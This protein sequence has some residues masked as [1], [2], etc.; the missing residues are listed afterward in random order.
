MRFDDSFNGDHMGKEEMKNVQAV[1]SGSHRY[2]TIS[3][4]GPDREV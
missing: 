1:A 2:D 4:K 3:M